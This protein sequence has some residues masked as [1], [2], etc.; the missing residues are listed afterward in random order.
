MGEDLFFLL[1]SPST[2]PHTS[3]SRSSCECTS[4]FREGKNASGRLLLGL[5][6]CWLLPRPLQH[7]R[8]GAFSGPCFLP[9]R[10]GR[11]LSLQSVSS[12]DLFWLFRGRGNAPSQWP[13]P[14]GSSCRGRRC[15][16]IA[17]VVGP[18]VDGGRPAGCRREMMVGGGAVPQQDICI[19]LNA[20]AEKYSAG[21][22]V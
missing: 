13:G 17:D 15:S 6:G 22:L 11:F 16:A 9:L 14:Q 1:A 12:P 5:V 8:A 10:E 7:P 4:H 18:F 21:Y 19:S 3:L 2:L 20:R